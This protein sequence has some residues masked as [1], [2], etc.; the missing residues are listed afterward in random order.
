MRKILIALISLLIVSTPAMSAE[1]NPD[2]E[3][4]RVIGGM[5]SLVSSLAMNGNIN[6]E[7]NQLRKYFS[8]VPN[9]WADDNRISVVKN[10]IWAGVSVSKFSTSKSF[11]RSHA[12]ELGIMDSPGGDYWFSGEFAWIKAADIA[13]GKLKPVTL[14]AAKGSGDDKDILFF[15][16]GGQNTW[17]QEYP[18]FTKKAAAEILRLWGENQAGLHKPKGVS[19]SIY[20]SVKPSAVRKPADIH[21]KRDKTFQEELDMDMGDVIFRP[22]PNTTYRDNRN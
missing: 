12:Q 20:E 5:Y 18:V 1:I 21:T 7:L 17:W 8:D 10:E 2:S 3:I 14:R 9:N 13:G 4:H 15:S 16:T 11:L 22:I 6:P 19:H